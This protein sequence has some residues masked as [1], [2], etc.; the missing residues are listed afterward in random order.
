MKLFKAISAAKTIPFVLDYTIWSRYLKGIDAGYLLFYFKQRTEYENIQMK[1]LVK[2]S[3]RISELSPFDPS[4]D[5]KYKIEILNMKTVIALRQLIFHWRSAKRNAINIF[6][7][8][9]IMGNNI[10]SNTCIKV[11]C[12]QS[13]KLY[14]FNSIN[15]LLSMKRSLFFSDNM[16]TSPSY[17]KNPYTN[18]KWTP[19]QMVAIYSQLQA[20]HKLPQWLLLWRTCSFDI[21]KWREVNHNNLSKIAITNYYNDEITS[22]D[23]EEE[24]DILTNEYKVKGLHPKLYSYLYDKNDPIIQSLIDLFIALQLYEIDL[25]RT[26]TDNLRHFINL[27]NSSKF[28]IRIRKLYPDIAFLYKTAR[29]SGHR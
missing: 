1:D 23:I 28:R 20:Y 11:W 3:M 14:Q 9:D 29:Y 19:C 2:M 22:E 5:T 17:P 6:N 4:L 24:I 7:K 15:L 25:K 26:F 10:K 21:S 12:N 18:M 27:V 16:V 13:N 8:K